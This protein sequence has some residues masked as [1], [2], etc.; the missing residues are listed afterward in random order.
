MGSLRDPAEE[1]KEREAEEKKAQEEAKGELKKAQAAFDLQNKA[2]V[3]RNNAGR[4]EFHKRLNEWT[5]RKEAATKGKKKFSE[6]EPKL[7]Y[8]SP[9]EVRPT[10]KTWQAPAAGG[11][12]DTGEGGSNGG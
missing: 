12:T 4:E 3:A 11:S 8:L 10:A 1:A 9:P 7:G 2:R 6:P 5:E